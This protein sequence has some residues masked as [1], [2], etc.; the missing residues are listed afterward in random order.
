VSA[1]AIMSPA[2][3]LDQNTLSEKTRLDAAIPFKL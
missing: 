1:Y 2:L 3:P